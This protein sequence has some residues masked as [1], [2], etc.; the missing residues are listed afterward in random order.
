MFH[1]CKEVAPLVELN[2]ASY[3]MAATPQGPALFM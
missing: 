2:L 3:G 1:G